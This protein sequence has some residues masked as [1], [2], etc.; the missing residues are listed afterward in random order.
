MRAALLGLAVLA[1]CLPS[2][3]GSDTEPPCEVGYGL[4]ADGGC[5]LVDTATDPVGEVVDT[6]LPDWWPDDDG[7]TYGDANADRH[8]AESAPSNHVNNNDD[9]DDTNFL[10][11]PD[12][13]ELYGDGADNDCDGL[14]D[15]MDAVL[16]TYSGAF[17]S[18]QDTCQGSPTPCDGG[19]TARVYADGDSA[20]VYGTFSC[21]KEAGGPQSGFFFG[22]STGSAFS[23]MLFDDKTGSCASCGGGGPN[24]APRQVAATT[25]AGEDKLTLTASLGS[26][27]FFDQHGPFEVQIDLDRN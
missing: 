16:G 15:E 11:N 1:G 17:T 3:P 6:G 7:D 4:A 22:S 25:I 26:G 5:Y 20:L 13:S 8:E 27:C 12:A 23:G 24:V 18:T 9:C 21:T 10:V 2:F 19:A 14:T